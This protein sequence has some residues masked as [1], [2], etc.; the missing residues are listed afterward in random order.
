MDTKYDGDIDDTARHAS[1]LRLATRDA[2]TGLPNRDLLLD[3]L[4]YATAVGERGDFVIA[5]ALIAV[6]GLAQLSAGMS[7]AHCEML[8]KTVAER[9]TGCTRKCDTV[10]RLDSGAFVLVTLHN[11]TLAADAPAR[12]AADGGYYSYV[13]CALSKVQRVLGTPILIDETPLNLTCCI[14]VSIYPQDGHD[15]ETL[16][17]H[18]DAAMRAAQRNGSNRVKFF[19]GDPLP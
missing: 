6:D 2:L 8:L 9:L 14:G 11:T 18:A 5:T 10:A 19:T 13:S 15:A 4:G 3:R 17:L 16:L 12:P 1:L 7:Q